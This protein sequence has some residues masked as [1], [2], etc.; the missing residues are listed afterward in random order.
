MD[1]S[2]PTAKHEVGLEQVTPEKN[3][4]SPNPRLATVDSLVPSQRFTQGLIT[5][6]VVVP[7]A[8]K[9]N[10]LLTH[11][12]SDKMFQSPGAEVVINVQLDPFQRAANGW[13]SSLESMMVPTA[14]QKVPFG[15]DTPS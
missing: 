6:N 13:A 3:P 2:R 14:R 4:S 7:P 1:R 5:P 15:H 10:V 11:D 9:Q 8:A 12:T